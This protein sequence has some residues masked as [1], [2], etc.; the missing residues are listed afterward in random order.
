MA[1]WASDRCRGVSGANPDG[2]GKQVPLQGA[3]TDDFW[4]EQHHEDISSERTGGVRAADWTA[5]E[6]AG[7]FEKA[8]AE[9]RAI[10]TDQQARGAP[11]SARSIRPPP[12]AAAG[13][14]TLTRGEDGAEYG[15]GEV[16]PINAAVS[17][18]L[19]ADG[20][21]AAQPKTALME[22]RL[23]VLSGVYYIACERA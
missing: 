5:G 4:K 18:G 11:R 19:T 10:A 13:W 6:R 16:T 12:S 20:I 22:V 2:S 3:H 1:G 17:L 21:T 15:R 9:A 23:A 7:D 14:G 8:R